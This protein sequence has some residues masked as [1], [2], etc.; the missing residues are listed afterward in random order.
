M[1]VLLIPD[2]PNYVPHT[3]VRRTSQILITGPLSVVPRNVQ[4]LVWGSHQ[5]A[6]LVSHM[7]KKGYF[8]KLLV[9]S[10]PR[11][12]N[13]VSFIATL[14]RPIFPQIITVNKS[15]GARH[16]YTGIHQQMIPYCPCVLKVEYLPKPYSNYEGPYVALIALGPSCES[17][18]S[19]PAGVGSGWFPCCMP[20]TGFP[21]TR[22]PKDFWILLS[23]DW[24][25]QRFVG[26]QVYWVER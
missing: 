5:Q 3:H 16:T 26:L 9:Q 13:S 24:G 14:P 25:L 7:T 19:F 1:F 20:R 22:S 15:S 6:L 17:F 10:L 12:R 2:L 21:G 8:F 4:S 23:A 18:V 11:K